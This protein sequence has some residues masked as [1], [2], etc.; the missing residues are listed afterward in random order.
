[1]VSES[2]SDL[3][4]DLRPRSQLNRNSLAVPERKWLPHPTYDHRFTST[5]WIRMKAKE[6]RPTWSLISPF[7]SSNRS[8]PRILSRSTAWSSLVPALTIIDS[9][10]L[11]QEDRHDG[12]VQEGAELVLSGYEYLN[13]RRRTRTVSHRNKLVRVNEFFLT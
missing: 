7:L 13:G 1:M 12:P 11:R 6:T 5:P 4:F 2:V 3:Y 8:L 10:N 9:Q